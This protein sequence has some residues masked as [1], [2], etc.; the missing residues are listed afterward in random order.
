MKSKKTLVWALL[1]VAFL[2][3]GKP[4]WALTILKGKDA[5]D[6]VGDPKTYFVNKNYSAEMLKRSHR[7]GMHGRF[8]DA[9]IFNPG[10][11]LFTY[12][13]RKDGD[14][15]IVLDAPGGREEDPVTD[16]TWR[17]ELENTLGDDNGDPIVFLNDSNQELA[18]VYVGN[19]TKV[20]GKITDAG[21][22]E[23][24][25]QVDGP[26]SKRDRRRMMS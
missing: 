19:A 7:D 1:T 14:H 8:C 15:L 23:V 26:K 3:I 5:R 4:A 13:R 6:H 16:D 12:P 22:L 25:I 9:V 20:D 2:G 24:S 10:G 11:G 21:Y 18:V 17:Q